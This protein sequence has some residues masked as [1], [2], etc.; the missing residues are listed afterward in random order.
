VLHDGKDAL[1]EMQAES[2]GFDVFQLTAFQLFG[3]DVGTEIAHAQMQ[4][5]VGDFSGENN[6]FVGIPAIGMT[7]DIG[8]RLVGSEDD[9]AA[10]EIGKSGGEGPVLNELAGLFAIA[11]AG[12]YV[13][14]RGGFEENEGEAG[15]VVLMVLVD[16]VFPFMPCVGKG[17][18]GVAGA[19]AAFQAVDAIFFAL[20]VAPLVDSVTEQ[21]PSFSR[22]A[23]DFR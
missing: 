11:R 22:L 18:G 21:D 3:I 9:L 1:Q 19:E 7:D 4:V 12:G 13:Q 14:R 16:K 2:A 10:D 8:D 17:R 6:G 23:G 15:I 20:G 5:A